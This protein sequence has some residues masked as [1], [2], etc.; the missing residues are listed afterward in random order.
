MRYYSHAEICFL[1]IERYVICIYRPGA[2][3]AQVIQSEPSPVFL[4]TSG[5]FLV[6]KYFSVEM[7]SL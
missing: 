1:H 4:S 2:Q 6:V 7:G 5:N 3:N